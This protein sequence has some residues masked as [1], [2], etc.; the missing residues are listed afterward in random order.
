MIKSPLEG[1]EGQAPDTYELDP[2]TLDQAEPFQ[3]TT[4]YAE[5]PPADAVSTNICP[6]YGETGKDVPVSTPRRSVRIQAEP[7]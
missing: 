4:S 2:F 3:S 7:V 5:K 6:L 1:E